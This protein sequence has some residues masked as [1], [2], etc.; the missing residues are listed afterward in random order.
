MGKKRTG[1]G[2][3][4]PCATRGQVGKEQV[5]QGL[6]D[7][8][9]HPSRRPDDGL[10]QLSLAHRA[11]DHLRAAKEGRQLRLACCLRVEVG[12]EADEHCGARPQSKEAVEELPPH[13]CG[14]LW[15]EDLFELVDHHQA[16]VWRCAT[17]QAA[18]VRA[19][20]VPVRRD[21]PAG[22]G[23]LG[24]AKLEDLERLG[25]WRHHR[26]R[27]LAERACFHCRHHA[28]GQKRKLAAAGGPYQHHTVH[29]LHAHGHAGTVTSNVASLAADRSVMPHASSTARKAFACPGPWRCLP[30]PRSSTKAAP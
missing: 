9:A 18:P 2:I 6:F 7:R 5:D 28:R 20:P 11:K 12:T 26:A 29:S 22:A 27:P 25:P 8:D 15:R 30:L 24:E 23:Y 1:A 16:P 21:P 17:S 19:A 4:A 3:D 14:H 10:S 13:V